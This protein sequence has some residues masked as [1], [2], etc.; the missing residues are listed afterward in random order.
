[1]IAFRLNL[2]TEFIYGWQNPVDIYADAARL[3]TVAARLFQ[4]D[5]DLAGKGNGRHA[6]V[7]PLPDR[8]RDGQ[9]HTIRVKVAGTDFEL[10]NTPAESSCDPSDDSVDDYVT[11]NLGDSSQLIRNLM[12]TLLTD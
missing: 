3:A 4:P 5:L 9:P 2:K 12:E 11:L 10:K 7:F 8:L 6:F 1:V